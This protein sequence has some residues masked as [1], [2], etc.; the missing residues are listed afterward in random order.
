MS[1]GFSR[2]GGKTAETA[3]S[4]GIWQVNAPVEVNRAAAPAERWES[5]GRESRRSRCGSLEILERATA[6]PCAG[7]CAGCRTTRRTG[8]KGICLNGKKGIC[9]ARQGRKHRNQLKHHSR[10]RAS[11]PLFNYSRQPCR[12]CR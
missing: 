10:M 9:R 1:V 3:P 11:D 2:S 4:V 12:N 7:L 6:P 8:G 5:K